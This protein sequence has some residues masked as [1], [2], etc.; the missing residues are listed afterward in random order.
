MK[1]Y[2]AILALFLLSLQLLQNSE[3]AIQ[4]SDVIKDLTPCI[5]YLR[6]GS[7]SPSTACCNGVSTLAS[8]ASTTADKRAACG[9]I[10][11]A[12][13][14]IK[15][16]TSA[17]QALPG[18]CGISLPFTVSTSLDCSKYDRK[19]TEFYFDFTFF[20]ISLNFQS[21]SVGFNCVSKVSMRPTTRIKVKQENY[22]YNQNQN[23]YILTQLYKNCFRFLLH[24]LAIIG[25]GDMV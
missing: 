3:A 4:C 9:C 13:P 25:H 5:S 15:P 21:N 8:A 6:S 17:A 16:S 20:S 19:T 7:G 23:T 18:S 1:Q 2:L 22:S 11:S 24:Q 10:K 14:R 12:V